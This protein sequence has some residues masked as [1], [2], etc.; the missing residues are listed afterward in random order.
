LL[1]SE[2]IDAFST[3]E[4]LLSEALH[5]RQQYTTDH[6]RELRN[7]TGKKTSIIFNHL[8][9][10]SIINMQKLSSECPHECALRFEWISWSLLDSFGTFSFST[11]AAI[12]LVCPS[13]APPGT[14]ERD[15]FQ[16]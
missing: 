16:A 15:M 9:S 3:T 8:K 4:R 13:E 12:P 7:Y 6:Y 10:I 2:S 14:T 5:V 11:L 1:R